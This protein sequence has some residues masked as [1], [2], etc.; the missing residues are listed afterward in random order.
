MWAGSD[1]VGVDRP[2]PAQVDGRLDLAL[3]AGHYPA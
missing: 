2:V 1:D 3:G